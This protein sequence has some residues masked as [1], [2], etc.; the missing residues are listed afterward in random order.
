MKEKLLIVLFLFGSS[1]C[2]SQTQKVLNGAVKSDDFPLQ[3]IEI[4]NQTSQQITKSDASGNFSLAVKLKDEI[5]F[6]GTD[7]VS[8]S[9]TITPEILAKN[10]LEISLEKKAIQIDEVVVER[11]DA[12]SSNYMQKII[13]KRY[14][15]DGQTAIKNEQIYTGSITDGLNLVAVGKLVGKLFKKKYKG[16]EPL[17]DLPFND[18]VT[19]NFNQ[20]FFEETLKIKPDEMLL[21]LEFCQADPK[22]ETISQN[23]NTLGALDFLIEKNAEFKKIN[24]ILSTQ[25]P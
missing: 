4:I 20:K 7:Y 6:Y 15:R 13:D 18:F 2:F 14:E 22:S 25:K 16:K 23:G 10:S 8:F 5:I 17:P 24:R 11:E 21:F 9:I 12:W 1:F 19:A 3:G